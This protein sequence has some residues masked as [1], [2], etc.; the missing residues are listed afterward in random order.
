ML[1]DSCSPLASLSL[2]G[3]SSSTSS[4]PE[5]FHGTAHHPAPSSAMCDHHQLRSPAPVG[6]VDHVS[7]L[8]ENF[9]ELVETEDYSDITLLVDGTRFR[10]HK[11]I[12]AARSE[13]FRLVIFQM[14]W[15]TL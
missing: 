3:K 7:T 6:V 15:F 13:F 1:Y 4:Q 14:I 12:L 2:K 9:A 5:P 8:S 11:V 10:S